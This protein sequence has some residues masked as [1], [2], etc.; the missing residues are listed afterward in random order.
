MLWRVIALEAIAFA[1]LFTA[2][3]L[4]GSRGDGKY[5]PA[6]IHNYP[7]DKAMEDGGAD[8]PLGIACGGD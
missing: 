6:A 8:S 5:T 4:I 1:A 7:H 3:V 2:I